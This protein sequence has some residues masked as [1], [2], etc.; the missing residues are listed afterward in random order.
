MMLTARTALFAGLMAMLAPFAAHAADDNTV[1]AKGEAAIM[2]GDLAQAKERATKAALRDAVERKLGTYVASDTQTK[3]FALVKDQILTSAQGYVSS[4]DVIEEKQDGGSMV[5]RIKAKVASQKIE[6]DAQARGLALRAM[7]FPRMAI[8]IAEQHL[9]QT[10]PAFGFD[11]NAPQG[12]QAFTVD[13][14]LVEN[15]L[16]GDWTEA[17]FTFVDMEALSGKLKA[18]KV[19]STNPSADDVRTIANLSDAD[20]IIVGTA[21]AT[22]QGDLGKLLNDKSGD[23]QMTSCK[24]A[25]TARVFNADSGEILATSEASKTALHIDSL[26]CDRNALSAATKIFA[27]DLQR[28]I[29]ESWNKRLMGGSRVRMTVKVDSFK[30][31]SEFKNLVKE[32]IRGVQAVDQKSFKDGVADLDLRIDGGDAEALAGDLDSRPLGGKYKVKVTGVTSN[33]ISVEVS[34]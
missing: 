5:V 1:E 31:L 24:G 8:M 2:N 15:L 34:K 11:K 25:I 4:Y 27:A 18:A 22:K 16:I 14:R 21:I 32:T 10:A 26:V 33:T 9:G 6:A 12:G 28:K 29:L 30:S 3:D 17:G 7:K 13:M 20:V 23:V 19:V